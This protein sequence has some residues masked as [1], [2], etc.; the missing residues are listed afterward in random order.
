MS[1]SLNIV[2]FTKRTTALFYCAKDIFKTSCDCWHRPMVGRLFQSAIWC[3]S[4][5]TSYVFLSFLIFS[6]IHTHGN[7]NIIL[8]II[9]LYIRY[10]H[11]GC[12]ACVF[13]FLQ[14]RQK[15]VKTLRRPHH[16]RQIPASPNE[17]AMCLTG[18]NG[19]FI[20]FKSA[21]RFFQARK[22][23]ILGGFEEKLKIFWKFLAKYFAMSNIFITFAPENKPHST[24]RRET[25]VPNNI[26]IIWWFRK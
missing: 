9:L 25:T 15:D 1:F 19:Q 20:S 7:N 3:L 6:Q 18:L 5:L 24:H 2:L 13:A 17:A 21:A 16:Q 14:K 4:V 8:I 26:Q 23:P 11:S 22:R 10:A 12:A